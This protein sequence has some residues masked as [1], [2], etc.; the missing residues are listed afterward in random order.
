MLGVVIF[1]KSAL[2][3]QCNRLSAVSSSCGALALDHLNDVLTNGG[4]LIAVGIASAY[5]A[6]WWFDGAACVFLALYMLTMWAIQGREQV[7]LLTSEVAPSDLLSRLTYVALMHE[8][9]KVRFVD[10]IMAYSTGARVQAEIDIGLPPDMP[11]R[12]AH[13]IGEQLTLKIEELEDVERAFVHMD[14]EHDHSRSIEVRGVCARAQL[15]HDNNSD[16]PPS[17]KPPT[18]QHV[19]PWSR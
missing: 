5:P 19:D 8:P 7:L 4:T 17:D 1:V 16:S 3:W 15:H 9:E 10:T 13:D 18:T 6:L 14:Y 12:E 11:L 2:W